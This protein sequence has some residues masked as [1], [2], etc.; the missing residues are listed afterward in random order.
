LYGVNDDPQHAFEVATVQDQQAA[1]TKVCQQTSRTVILPS[2]HRPSTSLTAA[3]D[4]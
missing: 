2:A 4:G 3:P 1:E